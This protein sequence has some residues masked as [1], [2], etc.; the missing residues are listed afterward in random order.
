MKKK[1]IFYMIFV[2]FAIAATYNIGML[3]NCQKMSGLILTNI[4]ALANATEIGSGDPCYSDGKYN[5]DKP[6]VVKCGSPCKYEHIELPWFPST[7]FCPY[8]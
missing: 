3:N 4:E 2:M 7:S 1:R 5:I 6:Q 8:N